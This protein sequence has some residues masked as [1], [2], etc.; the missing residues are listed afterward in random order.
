MYCDGPVIVIPHTKPTG[1][2][3]APCAREHPGA[4]ANRMSLT[5]ETLTPG[6]GNTEPGKEEKPASHRGRERDEEKKE[7][8]VV[9]VQAF[10]TRREEDEEEA[11]GRMNSVLAQGGGARNPAKHLEKRGTIRCISMPN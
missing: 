6:S 10:F 1:A 8:G 7:S 3:T 2:D 5:A 9:G 11:D 4:E